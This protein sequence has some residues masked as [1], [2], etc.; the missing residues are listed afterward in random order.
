M[1]AGKTRQISEH[2]KKL[3]RKEMLL[4]C[5]LGDAPGEEVNGGEIEPGFTTFGEEFI[6][7]GQATK[8]REP[9]QGAFDD[10]A[11][12]EDLEANLAGITPDNGQVHVGLVPHPVVQVVPIIAPI[13]EDGLHARHLVEP[14][15]Q[16]DLGALSILQVCPMDHRIQQT[17]QGVHQD[18][19][20]ASQHLFSPHRSRAA[21]RLRSF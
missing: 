15:L 1:A 5:F 9:S 13:S 4:V 8:A 16:D 14:V 3:S 11:L 12:G 10:P 21:P 17:A 19:P 2:V 6:V 7:F 18:V 20:L